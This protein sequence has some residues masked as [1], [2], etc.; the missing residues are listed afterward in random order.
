MKRF[1]FAAVLT[2]MLYGPIAQATVVYRFNGDFSSAFDFE[3]DPRETSQASF[4]ITT[5]N[6]IMAAGFFLPVTSSITGLNT[7]VFSF[8]GEQEIYPNGFLTGKVSVGL[9]LNTTAGISTF[10]YFFDVGALLADGTYMTVTSPIEGMNE[11]GQLLNLGN[12]GI[13]TLVVSG[14]GDP[15]SVPEPMS[16]ALLGVALVGLAASRR[17]TA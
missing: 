1:I 2:A 8:S 15:T 4:S 12:A 11:F 16:L 17:R 9:K 7:G 5:V 6:P 13:A 14:I 3:T 10:Y